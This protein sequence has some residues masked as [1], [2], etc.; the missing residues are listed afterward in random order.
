MVETTAEWN[1]RFV[2]KK[3]GYSRLASP[4]VHSRTLV[5]NKRLHR[6]E[7]TDELAGK[8]GHYVECLFH[9]AH[10]I[11]PISPKGPDVLLDHGLAPGRRVLGFDGTPAALPE[12]EIEALR[13]SLGSELRAE[14]HP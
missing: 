14:P 11:V 6:L 5:W 8:G 2:G 10:G 1:D 7:G 12:K 3:Y 9:L 13:T 4:V